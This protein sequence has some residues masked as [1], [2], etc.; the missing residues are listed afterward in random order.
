[1]GQVD[2]GRV[3]VGGSAIPIGVF[4]GSVAGLD[5]LLRE[6]DIAAGDGVQIRFGGRD[7]LH[8]GSPG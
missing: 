2:V 7:L 4:K 8:G 6:G 1:M 3:M 5:R